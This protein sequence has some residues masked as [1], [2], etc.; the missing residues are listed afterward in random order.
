MF[1]PITTIQGEEIILNLKFVVLIHGFGQG[2]AFKMP[3]GTF[4]N[5][6]PMKPGEAEKIIEKIT[7]A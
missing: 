7:N 5:S 1:I 6:G 2:L 3:D 4:I